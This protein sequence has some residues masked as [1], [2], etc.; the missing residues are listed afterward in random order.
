MQNLKHNGQLGFGVLYGALE[1]H[2][3]VVADKVQRVEKCFVIR[4][5]LR[6]HGYAADGVCDKFRLLDR[7]THTKPHGNPSKVFFSLRQGKMIEYSM[8]VLFMVLVFYIL[9][10]LDYKILVENG[11]GSI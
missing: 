5:I 3:G 4:G 1:A 9:Q 10:N 11:Y 7:H 2:A 6:C 8:S